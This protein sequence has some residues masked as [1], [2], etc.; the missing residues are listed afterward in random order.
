VLGIQ[1]GFQYC[2]FALVYSI[3]TILVRPSL[4]LAHAKRAGAP[5]FQV[6]NLTGVPAVFLAGSMTVLAFLCVLGALQAI[7]LGAVL[8]RAKSNRVANRLLGAFAWV[9]AIFIAAAVMTSTGI[10]VRFPHLSFVS[11]PFFFCAL[12]LLFLYVRAILSNQSLRLSD[13]WHFA[14]AVGVA[15]YLYP[16]YLQTYEAKRL[17]LLQLQHGAF[18]TW[19]YI[20]SLAILMQGVVYI[21]AIFWSLYRHSRT[22]ERPLRAARAYVF[23][24]A[25]FVI[26]VLSVFWIVGIFRVLK[27]FGYV[28]R[29]NLQ[30]NL[31]LPLMIS[32]VVYLVCY[33]ALR[34]PEA[35]YG[36]ADAAKKYERSGLSTLAAEGGLERLTA[37]MNMHKPY[38]DGNLTL[39]SL[40]SKV[41]LA[42]NHLSQIVNERWKMHFRNSSI[43]IV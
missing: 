14:P 9:A 6:H 11:D 38:L 30:E 32:V 10:Y 36:P 24:N 19:F 20:K 37:Y 42:P 18:P 28:N 3:G 2:G 21:A 41:G 1:R 22:V 5:R 12:P 25:R 27:F 39:H 17:I 35:L 23:R 7:L 40:S 29:L 34:H 8:F 31:V 15:L 33:S 43:P 26:G 4:F 13:A 16:W